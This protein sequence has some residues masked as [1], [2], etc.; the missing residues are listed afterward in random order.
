MPRYRLLSAILLAAMIIGPAV[1]GAAGTVPLV[2]RGVD[3]VRLA[4]GGQLWGAVLH[5]SA[6]RGTVLAVER[7]WLKRRDPKRLAAFEQ[8]EQTDVP[9]AWRELSERIDRWL[10]ER[11]GDQKLVAFLRT[12][13]RRARK[14]LDRL[15]QDPAIAPTQFAVLR[16]RPA[17]VRDVVIQPPD[18]KRVVLAAWVHRLENVESRSVTDLADELTDRGKKPETSDLEALWARLPIQPQDDAEWAARRAIVEYA[19]RRPLAFQGS[20]SLLVPSLPGQQVTIDAA[21]VR[22]L[23]GRELGRLLELLDTDRPAGRPA[24]PADP[25]VEASRRA[26]RDGVIG[27]RVTRFRHDLGRRRTTVTSRFLVRLPDDSWQTA[28]QAA[29]TFDA[30]RARP[31]LQQQIARDPQVQAVTSLARQLGLTG[32]GDKLETALQFG[33]ATMAAQQELDSRFLEFRDR[34]LERLDR[35][36]LFWSPPAGSK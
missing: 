7:G 30:S 10:T 18:R 31:Q 27:Y 22:E 28:W 13:R 36:P 11:A 17:E 34:Y 26:E 12:E 15:D 32:Q 21:L 16:L 23:L 19:L 9:A 8:A 29:R 6:S 35:P 3:R 4:G 5:R 33:A 20:G 25:L 14:E 1:L 2:A 24:G